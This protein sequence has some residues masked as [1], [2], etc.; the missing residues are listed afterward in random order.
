MHDI[1]EIEGSRLEM[2]LAKFFWN[3]AKIQ[4]NSLQDRL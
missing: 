1:E 4:F 3:L 2:Q